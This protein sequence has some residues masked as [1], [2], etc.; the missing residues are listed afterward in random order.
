MEF[1]CGTKRAVIDVEGADVGALV[2]MV[3]EAFG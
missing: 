1:A 3:R 2:A